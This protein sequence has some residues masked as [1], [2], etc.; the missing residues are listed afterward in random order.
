M[1]VKLTNT[2]HKL[3]CITS[4]FAPIPQKAVMPTQATSCYQTESQTTEQTRQDSN[5]FLARRKT[6]IALCKTVLSPQTMAPYF[7]RFVATFI[8]SIW[9]NESFSSLTS[10]PTLN[11]LEFS[12]FVKELLRVTKLSFSVVILS[13]KYIHRIKNRCRDLHGKPGSEYRLLVCTLNL[14]MKYLVDNTYS[15]KTWHKLSKIPL[16][17]INLAEVEFITQLKYDLHVDQEKFY[18]WL[19]LVDDSFAR[20]RTLLEHS[21]SRQCLTPPLTP[22]SPPIEHAQINQQQQRQ[23]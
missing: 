10:A 6:D 13:M 9:H 8:Y 20:F 4:I 12:R 15:N 21:M 5:S 16:I 23:F 22:Q 14:A 1:Q 19:W 3:S 11:L 2:P 18:A 7:P 17:E